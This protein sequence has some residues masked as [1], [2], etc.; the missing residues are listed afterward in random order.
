MNVIVFDR[1]EQR[2]ADLDYELIDIDEYD[3]LDGECKIE[4]TYPLT[5][6]DSAFIVGGNYIVIP[7]YEIDNE[8][9]MYEILA[10]D[11]S[12]QTLVKATCFARYQT[13][14][15]SGELVTF[16]TNADSARFA[17]EQALANER[18]EVGIV[19]P[20]HNLKR[21]VKNKN[22]LEALTYI[23]NFDSGCRSPG[24]IHSN[25][26]LIYWNHAANFAAF[27]LNSV[28]ILFLFLEQ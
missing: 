28:I 7:D 5:E 26:W 1:D 22:P 18:F 20:D 8:F 3:G 9:Q 6:A 15:G 13:E 21:S 11:D 25:S 14:L 24:P 23:A 17:M 19:E 12:D 2:V 10:T 4:L 16:N 27:V